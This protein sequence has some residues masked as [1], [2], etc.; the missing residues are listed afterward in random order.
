MSEP[1][2]LLPD[3][4]LA[5]EAWR[6]LECVYDPELGI[7]LVD[8]GPICRLHVKDGEIPVE[9]TLTRPGCL[10]SDHEMV[11]DPPTPWVSTQT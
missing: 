6:Q 8:L 5:E 10:M 1:R 11:W 4:L 3:D 9:M 2:L 7:N